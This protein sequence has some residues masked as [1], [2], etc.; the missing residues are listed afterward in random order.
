MS[1]SK[2]IEVLEKAWEFEEF[3][4]EDR[5][6]IKF[7]IIAMGFSDLTEEEKKSL[8]KIFHDAETILKRFDFDGKRDLICEISRE[9]LQEKDSSNIEVLWRK[10]TELAL[11][12]KNF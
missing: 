10:Y 3:S 7:F 1:L 11:R 2:R 5:N 8:S 12:W 6:K 4:L 9:I